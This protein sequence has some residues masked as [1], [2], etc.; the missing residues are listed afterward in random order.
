MIY[1]DPAFRNELDLEIKRGS[2][3]E[4]TVNNHFQSSNVFWLEEDTELGPYMHEDDAELVIIGQTIEYTTKGKLSIVLQAVLREIADY[5][6]T[7]PS[8]F[9]PRLHTDPDLEPFIWVPADKWYFL[10]DN[11]QWKGAIINP[12]T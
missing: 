3:K 12:G 2:L 8:N 9:D 10:Y 4:F 11:G 5:D 6:F 1:F 7:P